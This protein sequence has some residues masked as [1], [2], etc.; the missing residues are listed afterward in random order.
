MFFVNTPAAYSI[1]VTAFVV[2]LFWQHFFSTVFR[3]MHQHWL[4]IRTLQGADHTAWV[5][6]QRE[7]PHAMQLAHQNALHFKGGVPVN[8]GCQDKHSHELFLP[9]MDAYLSLLNHIN[10][11]HKLGHPIRAHAPSNLC[12]P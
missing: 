11:T 1:L 9:F 7:L 5:S 6:K 3:P 2:V 12:A 8:S 10:L 4:C